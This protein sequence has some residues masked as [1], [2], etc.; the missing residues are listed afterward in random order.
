[1]TQCDVIFDISVYTVINDT[2]WSFLGE[3]LIAFVYRLL[4][5]LFSLINSCEI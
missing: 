2:F 1:M 3:K 4:L 5:L